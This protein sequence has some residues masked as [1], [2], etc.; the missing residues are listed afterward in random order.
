MRQ[1]TNEEKKEYRRNQMQELEAKLENGVKDYFTSDKYKSFLKAMAKFHDYSFSNVMLILTQC[2]DATYVA[3]YR[4]WISDFHRVVRKGE[5]GIRI[6]YPMIY[7]KTDKD[8]GEEEKDIYFR[9]T[10]VFDISQTTPI[11]DMEPVDLEITHELASDVK[12]YD[13]LRRAIIHT[14]GIPVSFEDIRGDA[15]GYYSLSDKKIV[16]QKDMPQLQTVKT[17]LHELTHSV[18]HNEEA[19]KNAENKPD[20]DAME[21]QA[22]SCAYMLCQMLGLPDTGEEY[23]FP[24]IAAYAGQNGMKVIR[25]SMTLVRS[26]AGKLYERI[27]DEMAKAA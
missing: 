23:S 19:L 1:Y 16:I 26:T 27:T 13:N 10:V 17:M 9:P 11:S 15:K 5:K 24:Y 8:T 25:A 3:G 12:D 20:R 14:A 6:L 2:P 22:E 4:K 21:I 18:L 7:T